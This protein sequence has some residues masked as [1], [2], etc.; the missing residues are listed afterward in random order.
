[1]TEC[2]SGIARRAGA[3]ARLKRTGERLASDSDQSD[4]YVCP[5]KE[6]AGMKR[7]PSESG[8]KNLADELAE[9]R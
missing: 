6:R 9:L 7:N 5:K 2:D 4:V 1:V 3:T 8:T